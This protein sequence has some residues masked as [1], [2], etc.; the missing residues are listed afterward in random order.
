MANINNIKVGAD[1]PDLIMFDNYHTEVTDYRYDLRTFELNTE[2][3]HDVEIF[4]DKLII[5]KFRPNVWI[6]RSPKYASLSELCN[7]T[8]GLYIGLE[9]LSNH[10]TLFSSNYSHHSVVG[11]SGNTFGYIRGLGVFPFSNVINGWQLT[12]YGQYAKNRGE[13]PFSAYVWDNLTLE[14]GSKVQVASEGTFRGD[15]GAGYNGYGKIND[16]VYKKVIPDYT[17]FP[18]PYETL[19][20]SVGLYTGKAI[21]FDAWDCENKVNPLKMTVSQRNNADGS[22]KSA[23]CYSNFGTIK[24]KV[25]GLTSGDRLEYG[26]GV[27]E[28]SSKSITADGEYSI[29]Y[30][31]GHGFILYGGS[32]VINPVTIE[33]I[34]NP[35]LDNNGLVD[36]TDSPITIS[37]INNNG[38]NL[39]SVECW[40]AYLADTQ[41]YHRDKT[42]EN[43]WKKYHLATPL[44]WNLHR[45]V[46]GTAKGLK[47]IT[48]FKFVVNKV[49]TDG[50]SILRS[51]T[52]RTTYWNLSFKGFKVKVDGKPDD[53]IVKLQRLFT[54]VTTSEDITIT[55]NNG[56]NE[57]PAFNKTLYSA[58]SS[59]DIVATECKITVISSSNKDTNF[60]I[61]IVPEYDDSLIVNTNLWS[62]II[63][64]LY[65]PTVVDITDN[66]MKNTKWQMAPHNPELWSIIKNWYNNNIGVNANF[67]GGSIFNGSDLDE[68]TIKLPNDSYCFGEDNFANSKIETINFV[69]SSESSHFSAPQRLLRS[70][71]HLKNI[72][73][74]WANPDNPNNWLC[75]ANTIADGMSSLYMETYPERFINWSHYRSNILSE[76]YPCTLFQYAFNYSAGLVTIPS[77]PGTE[78]ENTIVT[79]RGPERAFYGCSSLVTVGPILDLRLAI[80]SS[81]SNIFHDCNKLEQLRIKNLN[82]GNWNF[83]GVTRN[84][85]YHGTLKSLN[86]ESVTYLFNNLADLTTS[87]SSKHEDTIDKSFKSWSSSYKNSADSSPDWDYTLT[88]ITRFSCRKRYA[89]IEDASFIA[90]TNQALTNMNVKVEGLEDGD[91][92]VFLDED[93]NNSIEWTTDGSKSITKESGIVKGFKLIS[94]NTDNRN[95]VTITIENGLDYTNPRVS[96]ANLYCPVEW[97]DKI[98]ND[99]ISAANVKGWNIY[100]DGVE[101]QSN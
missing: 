80:P 47:W 98:I 56:I 28:A 13:I 64:K 97:E 67:M 94:S 31:E 53:V 43:C 99:M 91:I 73:I 46:L 84:N 83:D 33:L 35:Y 65:I 61:E 87:D 45:N 16:G 100:I 39:P 2:A 58:N 34:D 50:V 96:N 89:S 18:T 90:Y 93:G 55:L 1:N 27:I 76:T 8:K 10:A 62:N 21:S 37:L 75:G 101:V 40:D 32:E 11:E 77:Y 12:S 25:S 22:T 7:S 70:A 63:A 19:Y 9:G 17:T 4:N 68:I 86:S 42:I 26:D 74:V 14:N 3:L 49:Y 6:I 72:N 57:I 23:Y 69:Q 79:H 85:V 24:I 78:D 38:I 41:I 92:V 29:S 60:D 88:T 66:V 44:G 71:N 48:P 52:A 36:I 59:V 5:K 51:T 82:H 20:L 95:T 15:W 81:S 54:N 30:G